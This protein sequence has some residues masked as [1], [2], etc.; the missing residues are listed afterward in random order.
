MTTDE[1]Y[2]HL[3]GKRE[4]EQEQNATGKHGAFQHTP[5]RTTGIRDTMQLGRIG[6]RLKTG[7]VI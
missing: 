7:G 5:D 1:R 3:W 2:P 6:M 4:R